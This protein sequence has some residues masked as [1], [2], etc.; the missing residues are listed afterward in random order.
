MIKC[1]NCG[2]TAQVRLDLEITENKRRNSEKKI[3]FYSC[4]CGC[5]FEIAQQYV[6]GEPM[7]KAE[8]WKDE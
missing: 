8:V 1:P 4:G 3:S 6:N 2:S 5:D 7:G